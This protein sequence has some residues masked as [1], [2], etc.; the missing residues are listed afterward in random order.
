MVSRCT[1]GDTNRRLAARTAEVNHFDDGHL[2]ICINADEAEVLS[3]EL[4]HVMMH[5]Y[6]TLFHY[7][8]PVSLFLT[9]KIEIRINRMKQERNFEHYP[10]FNPM[11]E[12]VK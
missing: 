3:E 6:S 4:M 5:L 1:C 12:E 9:P 11:G 8:G 2:L 7:S 10:K